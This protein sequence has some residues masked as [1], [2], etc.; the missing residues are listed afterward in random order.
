MLR[1]AASH[2]PTNCVVRGTPP[3]TYFMIRR[4]TVASCSRSSYRLPQEC[5]PGLPLPPLPRRVNRVFETLRLPLAIPACGFPLFRVAA[6]VATFS[7][8]GW[9]GRRPSTH[10][11]TDVAPAWQRC[12]AASVVAIAG[13]SRPSTSASTVAKGRSS[14]T[15]PS[16]PSPRAS[17]GRPNPALQ[18]TRYARR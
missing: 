16:W 1:I 5:V 11:G 8:A 7:S 9:V 12:R 4:G 10:C 18:R 14:R 3:S 6:T 17:Q 15:H 13:T 2:S